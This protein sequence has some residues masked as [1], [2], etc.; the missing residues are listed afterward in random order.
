M[1]QTRLVL[2]EATLALAVAVGIAGGG[3]AQAP[4]SSTSAS[5]TPASSTPASSPAWAPPPGHLS[6]A[7]WPGTPPGAAANLPPEVNQDADGKKQMA[8]RP[9]IRLGNVSTP[10]ITLFKPTG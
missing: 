4:A 6:M 1:I 7:I 3:W 2:A 5:S 8:G 9:Y 10:T